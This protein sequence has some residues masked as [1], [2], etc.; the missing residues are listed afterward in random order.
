M[1]AIA[2]PPG[3]VDAH[4]ILS[5]LNKSDTP[6]FMS[7]SMTSHAEPMPKLIPILEILNLLKS[8]YFAIHQWD[9]TRSVSNFVVRLVGIFKHSGRE[10]KFNPEAFSKLMFVESLV[11]SRET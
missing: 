10:L 8:R 9:R 2:T 11:L 7:M 5:N 1:A 3:I 4:N 6:V